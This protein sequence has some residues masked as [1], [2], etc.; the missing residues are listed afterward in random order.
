MTEALSYLKSAGIKH[1]RAGSGEWRIECPKCSESEA[2]TINEATGLWHCFRASCE[3]GGN[4]YQ[5]KV[6]RGDA[7]SVTVQASDG[8]SQTIREYQAEKLQQAWSN[9]HKWSMHAWTENLLKNPRAEAARAYLESRKIGQTVIGAC[10]LGWVPG[11]PGKGHVGEGMISIPYLAPGS[12]DRPVCIKLR[13]VP[14]EPKNQKGEIVRYTRVKGGSSVLFVPLRELKADVPLLIVGGEVDALSVLQALLD[15]GESIDP[16]VCGVQV[17]SVP[18]GESGWSDLL[19]SQIEHV[20]RVILCLDNDKGGRKGIT[21]LASS[22]GRHRCAVTDW[23]DGFNDGNEALQA[24]ALDLFS[25]QGM[26]RK[27]RNMGGEGVITSAA[28]ADRLEAF[29][30]PGGGGTKGVSTGLSV[31]DGLIAGWRPGEVTLLTGHTGTGKTTLAVQLARLQLAAGRR[32]F[33]GAFESGPTFWA[34]K[35]CWQQFKKDPTTM[36]A[37][38]CGSY[39]RE[40]ENLWFLDHSGAIEVASWISTLA[41]LVGPAGVEFIVGDHLHFM[42]KAASEREEQ[43]KAALLL[44]ESKRV[45]NESGAHLLMLAHPRKQGHT[46]GSGAVDDYAPQIGDLKGNSSLGQDADNILTTYRRR[47]ET[48]DNTATM[49]GGYQEGALICMKCRSPHG[50][51]GQGVLYYHAESDS[52]A[53][54]ESINTTILFGG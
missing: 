29:L 5:L 1:T 18:N 20:K 38:V 28:L 26:I 13:W 24:G 47:T 48:R 16:D 25:I 23:P 54:D 2:C 42:A 14:P 4:L 39:M 19:S 9:R 10:M 27:A 6:L 50:K 37:G 43:A 21:K 51:E 53:D 11:P 8:E 44:A 15:S 30:S 45:I 34:F 32:V 22:I 41:Y 46:F 3:A 40:L 35:W 17:A 31:L 36:P 52:Y 12:S 7:Y 33:V 49:A